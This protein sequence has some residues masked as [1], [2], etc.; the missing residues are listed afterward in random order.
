MDA[1]RIEVSGERQAALRFEEFPNELHAELLAEIES[2]TAEL[3]GRVEA[4]IPSKSGRLRAQADMRIF[5]DPE[6]I[7]GVVSIHGER[8]NDYA[9]AAALEYGAFNRHGV[10]QHRMWLDHFWS[11][12][13]SRPIRVLVGAYSRTA[14]ISEHRF[15]RGPLEQLRGEAIDRLNSVVEQATDKAE[16]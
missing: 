6:R 10:A 7:S 5:D 11:L 4:Q 16:G 13:L 1:I 15:L 2:L 3:Y 12:K 14:N 9:K 8:S